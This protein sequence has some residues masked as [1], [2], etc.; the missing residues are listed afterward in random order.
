MRSRYLIFILTGLIVVAVVAAGYFFVAGRNLVEKK[1]VSAIFLSS[2]QV[3]FGNLEDVNSQWVILKKVYYFQ[4]LNNPQAKDNLSL[5]KL[6][7]EV[8]QPLDILT[9]NRNQ[10]LFIEQISSDSR[11]IKAINDFERAR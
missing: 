5:V 3:Y 6:G 9:I 4:N 8:H 7:Q 10:I 1:G 2:G 11:V